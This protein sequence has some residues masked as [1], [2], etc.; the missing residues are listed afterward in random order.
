MPLLTEI[1]LIVIATMSYI[2]GV[3]TY[4]FK[5]PN[6]KFNFRLSTGLL[7]GAVSNLMDNQTDRNTSVQT[8]QS[9]TNQ[10]IMNQTAADRMEKNK[11][12][13]PILSDRETELTKINPRI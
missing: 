12:K 8:A 3:L 6:S 9:A 11:Y 5:D 2:F 10:T 4:C 1:Q 13:I 7:P